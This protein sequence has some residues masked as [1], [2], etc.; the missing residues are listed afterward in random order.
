MNKQTMPKSDNYNKYNY[1]QASGEEYAGQR[2]Y[3][4]RGLSMRSGSGVKLR[5]LNQRS[6]Y[7]VE[8]RDLT[9]GG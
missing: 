3:T 1:D 9:S 4:I 7:E 8:T 2:Q 5:G 6:S